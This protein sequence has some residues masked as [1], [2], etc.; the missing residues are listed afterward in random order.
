M[1]QLSLTFDSSLL[2]RDDQGR[3]LPATADQILAVAR[4]VIDQKIPRGAQFTSPTLVKD[5]LR[6]KLAG[7]E[8]EVFAALFLDTQHGLIE[9]AE[10]FRGTID[11][12]AVYPREVVKAALRLNAAAVIFA[13]NHPSGNPEPSQADRQIT[14]R[15]KDALAL[16]E[17]RTLDHI[18]VGGES[19]ESFAERGLL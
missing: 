3:Y 5:Y 8:H 17:V 19:T 13:H 2:V 6:T 9:Y 4:Q 11:S 18:V 14:Q 1:S 12:A 10:L 7:F 16:V 15:L